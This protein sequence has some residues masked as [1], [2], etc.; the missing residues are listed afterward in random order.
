MFA[1]YLL[2]KH[3]QERKKTRLRSGKKLLKTIYE[4]KLPDRERKHIKKKFYFHSTLMLAKT[5]SLV[6]KS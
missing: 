1:V 3:E 6:E 5:D 4:S 2:R